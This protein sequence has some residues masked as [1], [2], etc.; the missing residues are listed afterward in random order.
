MTRKEQD[1]MTSP[2]HEEQAKA[3]IAI[4]RKMLE[5][6]LLHSKR[7]A[8]DDMTRFTRVDAG[9]IARRPSA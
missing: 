6:L 2:T 8:R 1:K 7:N 3:E 9:T 5:S 4:V